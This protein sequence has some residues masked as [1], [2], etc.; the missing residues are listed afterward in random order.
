MSTQ[1]LLE[2]KAANGNWVSVGAPYDLIYQ[3]GTDTTKKFILPGKELKL[4]MLDLTGM[5]FGQSDGGDLKLRIRFPTRYRLYRVDYIGL[6]FTAGYQLETPE[7]LTPIFADLQHYG[8]LRYFTKCLFIYYFF[9]K[10]FIYL[11]H[12]IPIYLFI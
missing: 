12:I 11:F 5:P 3:S 6:S 9:F 10:F 2:K 1:Y 7:V 4:R 8:T